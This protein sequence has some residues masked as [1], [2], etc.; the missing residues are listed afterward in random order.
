MRAFLFYFLLQAVQFPVCAAAP[1]LGAPAAADPGDV[2]GV[3]DRLLTGLFFR[4]ELA[5]RIMAAGMQGNLVE[6]SGR[7]TRSEVRLALMDWIKQNPERAARLH[8]YIDDMGRT[9]PRPGEEI[10]YALPTWDIKRD[11]AELA[12]GVDKAAADRSL[13]DEEMSLIAQRLFD[14]PS[15]PPEEYAPGVAGASGK[16]PAGSGRAAAGKYAD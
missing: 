9:A 4:G 15:A 5:D 11:F 6:L 2:S 16:G 12:R 7:E 13:G 3:R 8:F 1:D 14:R 10:K